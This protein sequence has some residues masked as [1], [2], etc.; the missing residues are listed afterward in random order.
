[1]DADLERLTRLAKAVRIEL[2][3]LGSSLVHWSP[4]G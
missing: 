3:K 1:V 4:H 2:G